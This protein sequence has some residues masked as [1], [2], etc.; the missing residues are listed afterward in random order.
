M[1]ISGNTILITGGTSGIGHALAERLHAAGNAVIVA[2]RR[3]TL[4]DQITKANP[5]MAGYVLDIED[6]DAIAVFAAQVVAEHPTLDV[7]VANAGIMAAEDIQGGDFL[8]TAERTVTT[9]LLGPIRLIAALLP[10]LSKQEQATIMTVSSGLAFVPLARTPTYCAT[11]AA[12]HSYSMSLRHQLRD[13]AIEVI[14][15]APPAVQTDLMP[16]HATNPDIMTLASFIDEVMEL[17]GQNPT[18]D[19]ILVERVFFQRNAEREGRFDA[20]FATINAPV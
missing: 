2:G 16:G 15:L 6:P 3:Q 8:G 12:M 11:K 7:V 4:L 5:G 17:F 14:E 13:S 1:D 10:H 19:E 20:A 9:N 18:P